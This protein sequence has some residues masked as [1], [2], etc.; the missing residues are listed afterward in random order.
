MAK[1]IVLSAKIW[2]LILVLVVVTAGTV[3]WT[4]LRDLPQP[5]VV[6]DRAR[7]PTTKIYDRNGNL[8][9]EVV[10]P[11]DGKRTQISLEMLPRALRNATLATEDAAFYRHPGVDWRGILRAAR[12]NVEAGRIAAGGSTIT[13]QV[14]RN[15]LLDHEEA[16]ERTFRRKFREAVLALR[17]ERA[18]EKDEILELYLNNTYYGNF[19]YG[20]E[21]AA[22]AYFGKHVWEL[23]V[24]E[25]ALL[26]GLPQAP[27]LYNPVSNPEAARERQ[28]QVLRLM[29]Q[30]GYLTAEDA[31]R[32]SQERLRFAGTP[33]PIEAP[34]FVMY[35]L[36]QLER[37]YGEALHSGAGLRVTTTLDLGLQDVARSVVRRR[38]AELR[39]DGFDHNVNNAAVVMMDPRT[40]E[41][42]AMLGSPDYF[43]RSI[44]GAVNAA[45]MPR[46]PGSAL[47]PIT[48]ATAFDPARAP[49]GEPWSPATVLADVRATFT[50]KNDVRYTPINYDH[51]HAGPISLREA[52]ATSN[53]VVAVKV[54]DYVGVKPM[55]E[56]AYDL[57]ITSLNDPERYDLTVTLGGGEV[58]LLELT[59]AYATFAAQG[60]SREPVSILDV[61]RVGDRGTRRQGETSPPPH[62]PGSSA[63]S[64]RRVL[65]ERVSFL[66]S[67]VLSDPYARAPAFGLYNALRLN[68]PAAAKTGT[69]T[70][71]RDNWTMGYTP[72]LV[73]GVWV[74]NADNAPMRGVSGVTGAGPIWHD[75]MQRAL[76][77]T[78]PAWYDPPKG[79]TQVE[80]C[81]AS[82]KLPTEECQDRRRE[83]FL[84]GHEPTE[85]DDSYQRVAIDAATGLLAGPGCEGPTENR[86][87]RR[88]PAE[89][90]LWAR[91]H[92]WP[93]PPTRS[94]LEAQTVAQAQELVIVYPVDGARFRLDPTLPAESQRIAIAVRG[95]VPAAATNGSIL[96]DGEP[97]SAFREV[98]VER[99]WQLQAGTH[100]L[101][102]VVDSD[103]GTVRSETVTF[104]VLK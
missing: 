64:G 91:E 88:P 68:R 54:L 13:Q 14:A 19:A 84:E 41:I 90:V 4:L 70:D 71:F 7:G 73:T 25:S 12:I 56:T 66:I 35:V 33:F 97:I 81:A 17:L 50:T 52:L 43:D 47:K 18:V 63:Q 22:Q 78:T 102:A 72:Q 74:G 15:L 30:N 61:E 37:E 11:D 20:V 27:A 1:R 100:T 26:A 75:I 83:W 40:G 3:W 46:Q 67:D 5:S 28:S 69:T 57:G 76:R 34:H 59:N 95:D 36:Q 16:Q 38:L 93:F 21:A 96:L 8:L 55:I 94:C 39:D 103:A 51:T 80:I 23:D 101:Q 62:L 48:Y 42:L 85:F 53:N 77:N 104:E 58:T 24:A 89:A 6:Y 98:P 79:L 2:T 49:G 99:F 82:G 32:A 9:Y 10:P 44:D 60:V 65:D 31:E 86:V 92:D 87:F 29:V 45:L